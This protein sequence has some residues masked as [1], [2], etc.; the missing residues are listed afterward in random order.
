MVM[1]EIRPN[2]IVLLTR[3]ASRGVTGLDLLMEYLVGNIS[4]LSR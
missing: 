1:D 2:K 4:L 3:V